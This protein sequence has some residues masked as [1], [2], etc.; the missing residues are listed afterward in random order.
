MTCCLFE[1]RKA[2]L[3]LRG[4]FLDFY[5]FVILEYQSAPRAAK[6]KAK[7]VKE[8]KLR[9]HGFLKNLAEV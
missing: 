1:K 4:F 8:V 2:P 3:S 7:K 5:S 9:A 6:R